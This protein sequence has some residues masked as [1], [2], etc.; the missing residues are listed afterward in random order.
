MARQP[1]L[2]QARRWFAEDLRVIGHLLDERVIDAFATVPRERFV[3]PAPWRA[4][5]V[6]EWTYWTTDSDPRALYHDILIA[7]DE[8]RGLNTGQPSLWTSNYVPPQPFSA[9]AKK[10]NSRSAVDGFT[11]DSR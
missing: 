4:L 5:S 6:Y 10:S 11:V 3:G 7:L 1:S 9:P 2:A 8:G